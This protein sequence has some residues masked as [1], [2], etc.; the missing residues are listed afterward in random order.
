MFI[1]ISKLDS[2][3]W[4][5]I[6]SNCWM[7]G[8][9]RDDT[10]AG[11]SLLNGSL[12]WNA[13]YQSF[14]RPIFKHVLSITQRSAQL[15]APQ[16]YD[17]LQAKKSFCVKFTKWTS[18]RILV[19]GLIEDTPR[20]LYLKHYSACI[21]VVTYELLPTIPESSRL[22]RDSSIWIINLGS[23]I[24]NQRVSLGRRGYPVG[25]LQNWKAVKMLFFNTSFT[26]SSRAIL[27]KASLLNQ[28]STVS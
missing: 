11:P 20:G 22:L 1:G 16:I 14:M 18:Y 24:I 3:F 12:S 25:T 19:W 8:T 10:S 2:K 17:P 4:D 13:I 27:I 6:D 5:D 28:T 7:G 9:S 21:Q 15:T 23:P 26:P